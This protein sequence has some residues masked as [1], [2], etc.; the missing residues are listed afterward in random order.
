[1]ASAL[2]NAAYDASA[3]DTSSSAAASSPPGLAPLDVT[4]AQSR[5]LMYSSLF[6]F[7]PGRGS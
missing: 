6:S 7:H 5:M 4:G 1:M 3:A 2:T